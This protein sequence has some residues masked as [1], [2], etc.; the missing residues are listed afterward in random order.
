MDH[1]LELEDGKDRA[2]FRVRRAI[3]LARVGEDGRA[4]TETEAVTSGTNVGGDVLYDAAYVHI[5][6]TKWA[7]CW[8]WTTYLT[9]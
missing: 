6:A 1:A 3:F 8:G 7:I 4:I 2:W 9:V 5:L